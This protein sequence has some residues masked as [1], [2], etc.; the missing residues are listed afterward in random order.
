MIITPN[1]HTLVNALTLCLFQEIHLKFMQIKRHLRK[2]KITSCARLVEKKKKRCSHSG[3]YGKKGSQIPRADRECCSHVHS[4]YY[5]RSEDENT[6][7]MNWDT[8][9]K[10]PAGIH[11]EISTK[12]RE[13]VDE[14]SRR[15][16]RGLPC[17]G[18]SLFERSSL[19]R[20]RGW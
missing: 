6:T 5:V 4:R 15:L 12:K 3:E 13:Y 18:E 19:W 8:K 16:P 20:A 11:F 2:V 10:T 9:K 7:M 17:G 14:S 1:I